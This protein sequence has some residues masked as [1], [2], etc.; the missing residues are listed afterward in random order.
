MKS[1]KPG[2]STSD[3]EVIGVN[4][5]GIWLYV[6]GA[7]YFLSHKD[8]PWFKEA[9]IADVLNVR[10]LHEFHLHWPALDVDLSLKSLGTPEA[11]PLVYR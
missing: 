10:L 3:I 6:K 5:R 2:A 1:Q 4:S 7:E 9:T 11:Y 8:Y